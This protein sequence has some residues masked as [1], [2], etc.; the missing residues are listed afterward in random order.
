[1]SHLET[2][3]G[4]PVGVFSESLKPPYLATYQ[5]GSCIAA[6]LEPSIW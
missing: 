2:E 5:S 3:S 4:N 6:S 1:M